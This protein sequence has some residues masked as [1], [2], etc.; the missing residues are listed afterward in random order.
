MIQQNKCLFLFKE[1]IQQG[2]KDCDIKELQLNMFG[3]PDIEDFS[4]MVRSS[5]L[6]IYVDPY[7]RLMLYLNGAREKRLEKF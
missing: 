6:V 7:K 1:D 3:K 5:K 4:K 2:F